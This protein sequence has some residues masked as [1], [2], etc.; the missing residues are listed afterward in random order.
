MNLGAWN[1]LPGDVKT[2]SERNVTRHVRLQR[3]EQMAL[4]ARLRVEL[5]RHG[6]AVNDVDPAPFRRKLFGVY[7]KWKEQ[8]GR[9]G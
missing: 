5:A 2:V 1:G 6:P 9:K 7:L 3:Q 8:L 4:N